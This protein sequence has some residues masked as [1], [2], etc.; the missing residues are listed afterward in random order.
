MFEEKK[1]GRQNKKVRGGGSVRRSIFTRKKM[2]QQGKKKR[3]KIVNFAS[4]KPTLKRKKRTETRG[5]KEGK[6]GEEHE[7]THSEEGKKERKCVCLL[8][9]G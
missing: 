8:T 6:R 7:G 3:R 9:A 5:E 4:N 2:I 1:R